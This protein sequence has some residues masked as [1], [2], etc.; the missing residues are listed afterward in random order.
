MKKEIKAKTWILAGS[1]LILLLGF[2]SIGTAQEVTWTRKTDMPI[3]ASHMGTALIDGKFYLMT[4]SSDT[5]PFNIYDTKTDTWTPKAELPTS[6]FPIPI[7]GASACEVNRRIYVIGGGGTPQSQNTSTM[8]AYDSVT[9]TWTLKTNMPTAR[10]NTTAVVVDGK[11]FAIGGTPTSGHWNSPIWDQEN[12]V[13]VYDP[14][15]DTW[16][17]KTNMPTGRTFM[18]TAAADGKIYTIGGLQNGAVQKVV[19]VYDP[20]TDTWTKKTDAPTFRWGARAVEV[21]GKIYVI[22]GN[23]LSPYETELLA[24][25][26]I[27]DP[28]TDS[29]TKGVDMNSPK[30]FFSIG[31]VNGTIYVIGGHPANS[32]VEAYNTGLGIQ[33]KAISPWHTGFPNP[34]VGKIDGG[35]PITISGSGFPPNTIVTIDGKPLTEK[36]VRNTLITG[37]TPPGRAGE[38]EIVITAPKLDYP[39]LVGK[40]IYISASDVALTGMSPTRGGLKGG[41]LG[42]ITGG[43]F[44][45][46]AVVT[47]GNVKATDVIVMPALI[48]FTIPPGTIGAVDVIVT[49]PN[50]QQGT[51]SNAYTYAPP[52]TIKEIKPNFVSVSGSG[53]D[54]TTITGS[55][56]IQTPTVRIGKGMAVSVDFISPVELKITTPVLYNVGSLDVTV[57]NPDGQWDV[58]TGGVTALAQPKLKSVKPASGSLEGGTKI[59]IT[60]AS[61]VVFHGLVLSSRFVKGATVLIGEEKATSVTV[62][63]DHEI[64][65]KTP[66]NSKAGPKDVTV[67]N[68][69]IGSNS[70]VLYDAFTYNP[71]PLITLVRP[72]NGKLDGGTIIEIMGSG[73]HPKAT[74]Q[75]GTG[76]SFS[77]A[78]T[79]E[80]LFEQQIIFA[81]TPPGQVGSADVQVTNPDRQKALRKSGFTYNPLPKITGIR[82]NYGLTTG[83]TIITIEGTGF[84]SGAKVFIGKRAATTEFKDPSEIEA[85][86]PANPLGSFDLKVVN[87]DTQEVVAKKAFLSV[88]ETVYNYP[89]PFRSSQGTTFRYVA[90]EEVQEITVQI[91]NLNGEP[92]GILRQSGGDDI[93]WTNLDLNF[94]L[95]VYQMEVQLETGQTRTFQR[96]LQVE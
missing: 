35:E 57:V 43:N 51:L 74:V 24:L 44:Q 42:R 56:F 87:P 7:T 59:T 54:K 58:L 29:W 77:T 33:V 34:Q 79:V 60:G 80:V 12:V 28:Q 13:E 84:L 17:K 70:G 78:S 90:N 31:Q 83:G 16:T 85:V 36:K 66:P 68:P 63:S 32:I 14:E 20:E 64:I 96:L 61:N 6:I 76:N 73:F 91:F 49:N 21:E 23:L 10:S 15:T 3:K 19:E 40:F 37:L 72:D 71:L 94:G 41:N 88:S 81:T 2:S 9:D 75:I 4:G 45:K 92:I 39:L 55:G 11:I 47:V 27:Y 82:P 95:Y 62:K 22:G 52:P 93:K 86:T 5:R 26:E 1:V 30:Q 8:R 46:G 38:Q 50:G 69:G 18:A 65:A 53:P 25:V 67:V 89:N 48:N